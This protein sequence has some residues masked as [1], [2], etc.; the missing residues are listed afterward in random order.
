MTTYDVCERCAG[1]GEVPGGVAHLAGAQACAWAECS[2]CNG[3]G[4]VPV[5]VDC[6]HC[7]GSGIDLEAPVDLASPPPCPDCQPVT[8]AA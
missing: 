7:W 6:E 4:V 1:R 2:T 5:T 8:Q 3:S